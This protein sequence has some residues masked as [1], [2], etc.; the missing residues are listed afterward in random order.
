MTNPKTIARLETQILRRA[1]HCLLFELSDPRASFITITRVE[2]APDITS[3]K[4][5]Y[6]VLDSEER[7]KAERMMKDAAGFIQRQVAS[8]LKTRTMP[9]LR[10]VYDESIAK[11]QHV[12]EVISAALRRDA[13]IRGEQ[14][15][16]NDGDEAAS[17]E[18]DSED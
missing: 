11:A 18:P 15:G 4:I 8:V 9:H 12:D 16:P 6:S 5:F 14:P 7:S 10:W 13:G 3:G 2:L 17:E 1:A